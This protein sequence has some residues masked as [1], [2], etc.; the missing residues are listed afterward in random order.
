MHVYVR[1]PRLELQYCSKTFQDLVLMV[2]IE[3]YPS[4]GPIFGLNHTSGN[5]MKIQLNSQ[6]FLKKISHC[7]QLYNSW[8]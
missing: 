1:K 4:L 3:M 2:H 5:S 8:L 6:R 7:M